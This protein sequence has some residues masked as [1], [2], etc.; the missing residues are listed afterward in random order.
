M[1]NVQTHLPPE[2][3]GNGHPPDNAEPTLEDLEWESAQAFEDDREPVLD[4]DPE[5]Q[6]ARP[7]SDRR[8]RAIDGAEFVFASSAKVPA[9]WG[10]AGAEVLWAPGESLMNVGPD[11]V[12]KTTLMQQLMLARIGLREELLSVPVEPAEGRVLYLAMD[13]P[14]QA[15]R[16]LRRMVSE[17]NESAL[18]K[19]LAVWK[20]PLPVDVLKGPT[21]LA[22]WI[23][24]EFGPVSDV[25][26][27]SLKDLA[28]KLSDDDVGSRV[29][30]ARQELLAR[31]LE[32]V[33]GHHQRKEQ[34]GTGKPKSLA[35]VYGSRWLTAGAG[36]V[37]LLWGEPG[38]LV[39]DLRHLKQPSET[40]GPEKVLHDHVRGQS[41]LHERT[42]L[43][44]LLGAAAHGLAAK[45]AARLMF[46]TPEPKPNETE[47]AR[48]KLEGLVGSGDAERRD[49]PDGLAR[50][51]A[52][53][54]A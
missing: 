29:N 33:E 11:G 42:D 49:D 31:G 36:S 28:P 9:L 23:E 15:A 45:D 2:F 6:P 48:R 26:C 41:S 39:V 40:F 43:A 32:V 27:D 38:D 24:K 25:F 10:N 3:S 16:S 53:G 35:D 7:L 47:K 8:I 44:I 22:D 37:L 14:A 46:E 20:G 34:R 4:E 19:R 54:A 21:V 17:K 18:R 1:T 5:P 30:H 13:R 51:F 50:Y 52:K 12:G